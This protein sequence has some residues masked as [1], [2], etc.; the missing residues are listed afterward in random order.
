MNQLKSIIML[1]LDLYEFCIMSLQFVCIVDRDGKLFKSSS[2][3]NRMC[4]YIN[5]NLTH[6]FKFF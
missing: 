1:F 3:I 2:G 6:F 4:Y 5:R